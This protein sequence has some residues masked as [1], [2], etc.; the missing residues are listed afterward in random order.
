M[1]TKEIEYI[2]WLSKRLVHKY[3]ENPEI[4]N[5]IT[6]ILQRNHNNI[7]IYQTICNNI[8][9][10]INSLSKKI[11]V[12]ENTVTT[13]NS[14]SNIQRIEKINSDFENLDLDKLFK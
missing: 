12:S 6:D 2:L 7:I 5:N 9:Q 10:Y 14:V 4:I 11:S 3:G 1:S 8:V 13:N